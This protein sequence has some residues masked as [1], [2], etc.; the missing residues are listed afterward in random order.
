MTTEKLKFKLEL[1]ATYWDKCPKIDIFINDE[2]LY[3]GEINQTLENPN[4][5][6]FEKELQKDVE[7]NLIIK[8]Y[9]KTA[10]QCKIDGSAKIVKDQLLH[11]KSIEID[12]VD[13]GNLV[14]EGVYTPEYPEPW[15]SQQIKA[16]KTPEKSFKNVTSM[17]HNGIWEFKFQSPFYMWLLE[18]LY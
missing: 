17:G 10:D 6:E 1:Y 4:V 2:L 9:N 16:N 18:N 11:I 7:Y 5:I 12:D 8:R 3:C 13:I 15:Y 14:F